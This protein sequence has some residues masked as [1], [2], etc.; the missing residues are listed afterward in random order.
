MI[1]AALGIGAAAALFWLLFRRPASGPG[2]TTT[3]PVAAL[4]PPQSLPTLGAVS[5]RFSDVVELYRMGYLTPDQA[6]AQVQDL[7]SAVGRLRGAGGGEALSASELLGR[8]DS[9]IDDVKR[10]RSSL[11]PGV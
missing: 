8:M 5:T 7:E 11:S 1:Q 3:K 2:V 9:F 6:I 10:Y 4:E